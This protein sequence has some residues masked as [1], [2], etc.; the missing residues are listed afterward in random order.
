M[1]KLLLKF[2]I[3]LE[4]DRLLSDVKGPLF[5]RWLPDGRQDSIV[6]ATKDP[7]TK[8]EVWFERRGYA[9]GNFIRL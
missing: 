1:T 5:H 9:D 7:N 3:I 2:G 6:L 4:S 8:L